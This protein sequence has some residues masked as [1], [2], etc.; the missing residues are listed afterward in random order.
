LEGR[1]IEI[2][3]VYEGIDESGQGQPQIRE[4]VIEE[5]V[6]IDQ[7]DA[8]V[9]TIDTEPEAY[10]EAEPEPEV[11]AIELGEDYS[12][13]VEEDEALEAAAAEIEAQRAASQSGRWAQPQ[14]ASNFTTSRVRLP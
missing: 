2:S 8:T 12:S 14:P 9:D 10:A 7:D 1:H 6:E 3:G 11:E 4:E 5:W 13:V